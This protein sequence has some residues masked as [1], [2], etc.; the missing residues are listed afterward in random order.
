MS[1]LSYRLS[2]DASQASGVRPRTGFS[3]LSLTCSD[4]SSV[5]K[6]CRLRSMVNARLTGLSYQ[7][8]NVLGSPAYYRGDYDLECAKDEKDH[9]IDSQQYYSV[10]IIHTDSNQ[11]AI[12]AELK[13]LNDPIIKRM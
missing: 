9:L 3:R 13:R 4:I 7:F 11:S 5:N 12:N 8:I 6:V 2:P 1:K 10:K